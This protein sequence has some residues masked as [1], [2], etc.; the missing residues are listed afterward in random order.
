MKLEFIE[1]IVITLILS[2][3]LVTLFGNI[4]FFRGESDINEGNPVVALF[5]KFGIIPL[6]LL[7]V[8][9]IFV[10]IFLFKKLKEPLNYVWIFMPIVGHLWG[11][12]TW[13]VFTYKIPVLE[14]ILL[15]YVVVIGYSA[16]FLGDLFSIPF[17]VSEILIFV[18]FGGLLGFIFN[19]FTKNW[20][21]KIREKVRREKKRS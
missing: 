4:P 5:I 15:P 21:I 14:I 9:W 10:V 12:S 1:Y 6:A 19:V 13:I 11:V 3:F 8:V 17:F 18:I 16:Y 7:T 20:S 2:D